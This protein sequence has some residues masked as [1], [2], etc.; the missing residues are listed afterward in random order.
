VLELKDFAKVRLKPGATSTIRWRLPASALS[1]LGADLKPVLEPGKFEI[2]IG[3]S[4]DRTRLLSTTI[5]VS[6]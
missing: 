5:R 1:F 4:A 6:A 3:P 2:L